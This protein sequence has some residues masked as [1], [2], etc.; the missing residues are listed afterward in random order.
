M[1]RRS[2]SETEHTGYEP[3]V[4][5]DQQTRAVLGLAARRFGRDVTDLIFSHDGRI[6]Q[7]DESFAEAGVVA[8]A[9]IF[10][11]DKDGRDPINA[12][13]GSSTGPGT[14]LA[15]RNSSV[16]GEA[17]AAVDCDP[18]AVSPPCPSAPTDNSTADQHPTP[19]PPAR[20]PSPAAPML[21]LAPTSPA[22]RSGA[23]D[24]E[25]ALRPAPPA[26]QAPPGASSKRG[27]DSDE[28]DPGRDS[29][30]QP[31]VK[32]KVKVAEPSE[33]QNV[34]QNEWR[35]AVSVEVLEL[36]NRPVD[37]EPRD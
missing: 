8:G 11:T 1:A 29:A 20:Q 24:D 21:A 6:L 23:A 18:P 37:G 5:P 7:G 35:A 27:L 15:S 9:R 34:W 28:D 10:A 25:Q 12:V 33:W 14:Q 2:P 16:G 13:A 36:H 26:S 4:Q 32:K 22:D 3:V 19:G 30:A 31:P 17:E